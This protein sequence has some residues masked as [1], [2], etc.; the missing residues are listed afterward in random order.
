MVDPEIRSIVKAHGNR[1]HRHRGIRFAY[2]IDV[3]GSATPKTPPNDQMMLDVLLSADQLSLTRALEQV[4][5]CETYMKNLSATT[6]DNVLATIGSG[7][8]QKVYKVGDWDTSWDIY[9]YLVSGGYADWMANSVTGLGAVTGT[10]ELWINGEPGQENT[11]A[12]YNREVEASNVHSMRVA[13]ATLMDLGTRNERGRLHL[14]GPVG[15][16]PNAV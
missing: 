15:Y 7:S 16:V 6:N 4:Q 11:F 8:D 1:L 12:G 5:M 2:G 10:V 14:R 3:H 13:V 9:G